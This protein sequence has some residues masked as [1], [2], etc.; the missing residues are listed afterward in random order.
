MRVWITMT[1]HNPRAVLL[2]LD[3]P[4]WDKHAGYIG[5]W[6]YLSRIAAKRMLQGDAFA[7]TLKL[8]K[9]GSDEIL[10]VDFKAVD[11]WLA[12]R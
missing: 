4:K 7:K 11:A 9:H 6:N 10:T 3:Q 1:W 2:F 5:N 12:W 8:P